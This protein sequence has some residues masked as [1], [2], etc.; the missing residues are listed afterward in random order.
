MS[1]RKRYHQ[2]LEENESLQ[3]T[4]NEREETLAQCQV[5]VNKAER[6]IENTVQA[7]NHTLQVCFIFHSSPSLP[8]DLTRKLYETL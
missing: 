2:V 7:L 5:D 4:I 3:Q 6:V 1:Y 8:P